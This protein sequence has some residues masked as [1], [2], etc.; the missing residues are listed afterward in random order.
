MNLSDH[1]VND[2]IEVCAGKDKNDPNMAGKLYKK[3]F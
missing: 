3:H 2:F 1:E